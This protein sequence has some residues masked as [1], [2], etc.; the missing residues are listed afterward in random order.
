MD[1]LR[2]TSF[3]VRGLNTPEKRHGVALLP[4][5]HA[6]KILLLQ[7]T[8][9]KGDRCFALPG[10]Q[11][12]QSFHSTY[13]ASASRGVSILFHKTV[14]FICNS[15]YTGGEG[16]V[17][18]LKGTINNKQITI[19]NLYAPNTDQ[20]S[21]LISQLEVLKHFAVGQIILGGDINA[22]LNPILDSS[23]GRSQLP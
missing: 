12:A 15:Q 6:T 21:W 11:F 4:K 3:N 20:A 2:I 18:F 5:R 19:A 10:K 23:T 1:D 9:Y 14:S 22:T 13:T 16:R 17:L 7:E 8:H